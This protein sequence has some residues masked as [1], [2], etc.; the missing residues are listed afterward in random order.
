MIIPA[1]FNGPTGS[2]NGGYTAGLVAQLLGD[3]CVEVTLR[4]P[5]P[6]D[7]PLTVAREAGAVRLYDGAGALVAEAATVPAG[8]SAALVAGAVPPVDGTAAA[9]A[10]RAYAGFTDHPFPACY[11]C[12]PQR[13]RGDG[14]RIFPGRLPDGRTA[15]PFTAPAEVSAPTVWAALD[16]PGGWAIIAP[17]RPYVLGRLAADVRA[18][19]RPGDACVVVGALLST[20]GRKAV[21]ATSLYGPGGALLG[22]ARATWISIPAA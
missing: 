3:A 15:A 8:D 17:D 5:P 2:G 21:V 18:L 19:P 11:V 13:P 10:A 1:R 20:Q 4:L 9:A 22:A 14:L 16:C 12:G 7:T 6:L